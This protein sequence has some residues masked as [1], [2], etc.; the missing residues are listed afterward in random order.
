[1]SLLIRARSERGLTQMKCL[2]HRFIIHHLCCWR[3]PTSVK[4][5]VVMTSWVASRR[6]CCWMP[7]MFMSDN[8]IKIKIFWRENFI[9]RLNRCMRCIISRKQHMLFV[10]VDSCINW[11]GNLRAIWVHENIQACSQYKRVPPAG[12]KP[13]PVVLQAGEDLVWLQRK[14]QT[15]I[16]IPLWT[17]ASLFVSSLDLI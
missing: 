6:Y 9:Y 15:Q 3:T 10:L 11:K 12:L 2:P 4:H 13:V 5:S 17:T 16:H 14:T 1:M 7:I 8:Q